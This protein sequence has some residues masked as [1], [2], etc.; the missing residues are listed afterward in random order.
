M[1]VLPGT[2]RR[3]PSSDHGL[4]ELTE[5]THGHL[6]LVELEAT[7]GR[8]G[9]C[10]R[11]RDSVVASQERS[12]RNNEARA[13]ALAGEATARHTRHGAR[14]LAAPGRAGFRASLA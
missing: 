12:A 13:T 5:A 1:H 6:V 2:A 7:H 9:R 14:R 8:R 10:V 4:D 3:S 11:E